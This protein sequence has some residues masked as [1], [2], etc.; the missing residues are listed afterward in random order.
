M[1]D[2]KERG[3][4]A[5]ISGFSGAGKDTLAGKL[6]REYGDYALSVSATTRAE[7]PGEQDGKDY[8][9]VSKERFLKMIADGELLEYAEYVGN[10]YGTPKAYVEQKLADGENVLLV[11]EINGALNVKKLYSEAVL[12]Y[13]VPPSAAVLY[14]RLR[15]RGT[16]DEETIRKRL[17][18]ALEESE[19]VSG[20]DYILINDDLD[21]SA[22]RLHE[23]IMAQKQRTGERLSF[24]SDFRMELNDLIKEM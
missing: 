5:V 21:E 20:Y 6:I 24:L 1:S 17:R 10:Y 22:R 15:S 4:L 9:F 16:E 13:I 11:I 8:F 3:V 14:E 19:R 7:R 23:L 12:I 2:R 18:K